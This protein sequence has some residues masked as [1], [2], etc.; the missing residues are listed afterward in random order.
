[1][2]TALYDELRRI[3]E[4][5]LRG[6]RPHHTLQATALV[7]EAYLKLRGGRGFADPVHFLATASRVMRQVLVD[8]ARARSTAKRSAGAHAVPFT[9]SLEVRGEEADG[10]DLVDLIELDEAL[11]SLTEESPALAD[12]IEMRYFSGMTAEECAQVT[13]KSPH[14]VRHE[15]RFAHA[16]LRRHLA[17]S[18]P[19]GP[20]AA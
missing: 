2:N 4:R 20:D 11:N 15:L 9:A 12:L 7:N 18:H 19:D 1:M 16:W 13:G 17:H 3:A 5:H 6:E 8:Y 14:V 10:P